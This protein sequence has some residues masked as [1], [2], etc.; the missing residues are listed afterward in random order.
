MDHCCYPA[1]MV[2]MALNS[3]AKIM[4]II[5]AIRQCRRGYQWRWACR[6]ADWGLLDIQQVVIKVA[7]MWCLVVREWVETGVLQSV[8]PQWQ[9]MALN[10]MAKIIMIRVVIPS[11]PPGISMAMGMPIC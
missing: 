3:M 6:S 11:V 8:Q 5:V 7:A 4:V 9:P 10:S 1:S 2:P